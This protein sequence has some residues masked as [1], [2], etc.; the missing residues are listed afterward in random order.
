MC[1][2]T[3]GRRPWFRTPGSP[4]RPTGSSAPADTDTAFDLYL[5]HV[6]SGA[7]ELIEGVGSRSV[8]DMSADAKMIVLDDRTIY[9]RSTGR[10]YRPLMD[11]FARV[12]P[13]E[14]Q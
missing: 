12:E 9:E 8:Y 7:L 10:T 5:E 2:P 11:V 14:D 4:T 6:S 1:S 3:I 13:G